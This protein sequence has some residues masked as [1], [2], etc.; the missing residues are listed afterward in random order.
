MPDH[1]GTDGND[2]LVGFAQTQDTIWARD[3]DDTITAELNLV[4]QDETLYGG[5]GS[6]TY[7]IV[8]EIFGKGLW[9]VYISESTS[10]DSDVDTLDLTRLSNDI[11]SMR[12]EYD[13]N[14]DVELFF[15]ATPWQYA[16]SFDTENEGYIRL[17]EQL[18]NQTDAAQLIEIIKYGDQ[19]LDISDVNTGPDLT[20]KIN[21]WLLSIPDHQNV[22]TL[23]AGTFNSS[24]IVKEGIIGSDAVLINNI[25]ETKTEGS[26][27]LE[28]LG[29]SYSFESIESVVSVVARDG[30]FTE[31]FSE[32]IA[33]AVPSYSG[34]TYQETLLLVGVKQIDDVLVNIAGLDGSYVS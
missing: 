22:D 7:A 20:E 28:Y 12:V 27:T 11:S 29:V 19:I 16:A 15:S 3:G 31:Q 2:N 33:Q 1:Y 24:V 26:H 25:T 17:N 6:D 30:N 14:G 8:G 23:E 13:R 5:L 21:S 4:A 9:A 34:I 32:E 18:N 10:N